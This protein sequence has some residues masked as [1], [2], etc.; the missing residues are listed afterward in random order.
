DGTFSNGL[1]VSHIY[2]GAGDYNV[3]LTV[4]DTVCGGTGTISQLVSFYPPASA[5]VA[6]V[7]S[8]SGCPPLNVNFSNN[9]STNGTHYWNFIDGTLASGANISHTYSNYG[10]YTVTLDVNDPV[11]GS[12]G[13]TSQ[14]VSFY[15]PVNASIAAIGATSGCAPLNVSFTNNSS[16][17]GNHF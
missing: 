8:T 16:V 9:S 4:N 10:N 15:P 11:C 17:N 5:S 1:N 13:T 6:I 7:G 12:S 2:S 3:T 14:V